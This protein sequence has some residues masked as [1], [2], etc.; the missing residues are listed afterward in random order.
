MKGSGILSFLS[1]QAGAKQV[2]AL[3]ASSMADKMAIVGD[4]D[5]PSVL[6]MLIRQLVRESNAGGKN[7]HMKNKIRIVKGM[8]ENEKVQQ[9]VLASGKVDTII[10]EPIGVMLFHER[11]VSSTWHCHV[12][13]R[14]S[15]H[16]DRSSP[17]CWPG[18]HS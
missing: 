8:V 2:V 17:S 9:A 1:A 15:T 10:S 7:T 13:R 5:I 12:L 18:I 3:E 16:S 6:I 4:L 11:M 14:I